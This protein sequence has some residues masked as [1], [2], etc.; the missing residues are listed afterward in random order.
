MNDLFY[1]KVRQQM[2]LIRFKMYKMVRI[3]LWMDYSVYN[4]IND[5]KGFIT[6]S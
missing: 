4:V 2:Y 5:S 6:W 1:L 3:I